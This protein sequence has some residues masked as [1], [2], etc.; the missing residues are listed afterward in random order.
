MSLFT[1][2]L[3]LSDDLGGWGRLVLLQLIAQIFPR[4]ENM[5]SVNQFDPDMNLLWPTRSVVGYTPGVSLL[6]PEQRLS[7]IR[8]LAWEMFVNQHTSISPTA[9][10]E[11]IKRFF[12]LQN[13]D[14]TLERYVQEF[15]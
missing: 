4:I 6:T 14:V 13:D 1:I 15:V 12:D 8:D 10:S 3:N 9:F 7:F 11:K 5:A 2:D